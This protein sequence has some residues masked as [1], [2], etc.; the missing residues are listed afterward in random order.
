MQSACRC[1]LSEPISFDLQVTL[2]GPFILPG[3][4]WEIGIELLI[5]SSGEYLSLEGTYLRSQVTEKTYYFDKGN[6]LK[7]NEDSHH[8]I[9]I[10][11]NCL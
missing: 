4:Y 6:N 7:I 1:N 3:I 8:L 9:Q 10:D 11:S 5:D 2:H